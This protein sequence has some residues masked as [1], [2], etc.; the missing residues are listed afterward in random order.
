M[1]NKLFSKLKKTDRNTRIERLSLYHYGTCPFCFK[2][3]MTM[4]KLRID[5]PLKDILL[6]PSF[7]NELLEGGGKTTVPC[8]R[9]EEKGEI[10][11]LYESDDI[12]DHLQQQFR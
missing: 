9:I 8:L 5:M 7:R 11:W 3:R 12:V 10:R 4:T 2:V 6:N 1:L